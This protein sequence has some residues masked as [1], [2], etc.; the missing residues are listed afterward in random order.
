MQLR[1]L[2]QLRQLVQ[3]LQLMQLMQLM[4]PMRLHYIAP[5]L[6]YL[7]AGRREGPLISLSLSLSLSGW[8]SRGFVSPFYLLVFRPCFAAL[9]SSVFRGPWSEFALPGLRPIATIAR[10]KISPPAGG[11]PS[12]TPSTTPS[13]APKSPKKGPFPNP[14]QVGSPLFRGLSQTISQLSQAA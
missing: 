12:T 1:Q 6:G 10:K 11:D 13:T 7:R 2:R 9:R 3:I 8:L 14:V 5:A 4:Q